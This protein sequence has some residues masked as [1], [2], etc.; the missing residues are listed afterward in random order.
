MY[1][2]IVHS[3]DAKNITI[4]YTVPLHYFSVKRVIK[5]KKRSEKVKKQKKSRT[6]EDKGVGDI[7]F[8]YNTD[9]D[10][11]IGPGVTEDLCPGRKCLYNAF[12]DIY[13]DTVEKGHQVMKRTPFMACKLCSSPYL[14]TGA[15]L[16]HLSKMHS[17]SLN[18]YQGIHLCIANAAQYFRE[19][20][21]RSSEL[22]M[23]FRG[24]C[25]LHSCEYGCSSSTD[26][27]ELQTLKPVACKGCRQPYGSVAG[28]LQHIEREHDLYLLRHYLHICPDIYRKTNRGEMEVRGTSVMAENDTSSVVGEMVQQKMDDIDTKGTFNCNN[29]YSRMEGQ[30][31]Y[32]RTSQIVLEMV[33]QDVD[34]IDTKGGLNCNNAYCRVYNQN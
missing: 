6:S 16:Q 12:H 17:L 3:Y 13:V 20:N 18:K 1:P 28:V 26:A 7:L 9:P 8:S 30:N 10:A 34:E 25:W 33:Q 21:I 23:E 29:V 5:R 24:T 31:C 27:N 15:L 14:N 4:K 32:S 22:P 11:D 2:Y 19:S